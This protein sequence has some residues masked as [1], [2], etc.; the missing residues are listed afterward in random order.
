MNKSDDIKELALALSKTQSI[1]KGALKDS[2]NPFFKSKYADLASVWEACREPLA[3]NG[4]SVVQ[5]PC[6]DTP[7]SVA[8][9]TILMH[10]SGQWISSVFSMPVSKH[11]AQA[12]GSAITYARRYAL[13]AVVGI[14]PEDDD[15]NLASG[16]S[17]TAKPAY[18][19]P[20]AVI[21]QPVAEI[22]QPVAVIKEPVAVIKEPVAMQGT[23]EWAIAVTPIPGGTMADWIEAAASSIRFSLE[24][25]TNDI[26]CKTLY[27]SN[28]E[29]YDC[30][31]QNDKDC[32]DQLIA[33]MTAQKEKLLND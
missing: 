9:E 16:K 27:R 24:M 28:K 26:D 25:C 7:D 4:L 23:G 22:K 20:V 33:A 8:L 2:N 13:A 11:D 19:K 21:K 15:G 12:V 18:S 29:I 14:A 5:M 30:I 17:E 3:A 32:Y 1:L 10:T 31:Q 6:N